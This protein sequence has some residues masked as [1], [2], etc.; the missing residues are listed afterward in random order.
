[1]VIFLYIYFSERPLNETQHVSGKYQP[2]SAA[3]TVHALQ[4]M[5]VSSVQLSFSAAQ[6]AVAS[7]SEIPT[8]WHRQ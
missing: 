4:K 8:G 3:E 5:L 6:V 2:D 7:Y 1:M